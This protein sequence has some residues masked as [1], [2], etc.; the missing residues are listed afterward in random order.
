MYVLFAGPPE[1][2]FGWS[3]K[4]M[5]GQARFLKRLWTLAAAHQDSCATA[6]HDGPFEGKAL[7]SRRAAHKCVKR[8]GEAID[9][10]SFNTAIAFAM[11]CV[12][13]L[14]EA[15][16]PETPAERAAMGEAIGL[17]T[18]LLTPFA[19]SRRRGGRGPAGGRSLHGDPGLAEPRSALVV[20]EGCPTPSR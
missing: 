4:Q 16:Q 6:T 13:A 8:V 2:D 1:Q 19:P 3:D 18:R 20:D 11:E 14:Y 17:L 9:K 10:L 12:N 7:A 5:E 15:G